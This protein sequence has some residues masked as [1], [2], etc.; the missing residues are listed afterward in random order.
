MIIDKRK[1]TIQKFSSTL[2]GYET[3]FSQEEVNAKLTFAIVT[4][5]SFSEYLWEAIQ[6]F[7]EGIIPKNVSV[8]EQYSNLKEWCEDS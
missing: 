5:T 1:K 2:L 8:L 4:N 7:K 6:S 3:Q